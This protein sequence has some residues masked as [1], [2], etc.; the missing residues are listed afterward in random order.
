MQISARH[1]G[2]SREP[3]QPS[4]PEH[5]DKGAAWFGLMTDMDLPTMTD[6]WLGNKFLYPSASVGFFLAAT[7]T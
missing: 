5:R 6:C 3:A 2:L 7:Q 1:Q 4:A